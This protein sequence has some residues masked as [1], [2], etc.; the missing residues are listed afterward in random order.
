MLD[1]L[2]LLSLTLLVRLGTLFDGLLLGLLAPV[3]LFDLKLDESTLVLDVDAGLG[4]KFL[5]LFHP[6]LD[7]LTVGALNAVCL[8]TI[9]KLPI[10]TLFNRLIALGLRLC[11]F[12]LNDFVAL[13]SDPA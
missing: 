7:G 4:S 13:D 2:A 1:L 3:K 8:S 5:L 12:F 11:G 10:T 9:K 6:F